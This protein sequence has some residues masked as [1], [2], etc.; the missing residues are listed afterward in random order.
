MPDDNPNVI[1]HVSLGTNR[2]DEAKS[3]YVS[4]LATLGG[5]I[6]MEHPGAVA[7]GKTYPE[8]WLQVPY[9]GKP[10][11]IGNGWHVGFVAASKAEVDAFH[12]AALAAGA[13]PDGDPGHRHEYG[14]PYYGC[15]LRDLDGN[16]I[17]ATFWDFDLARK[18]GM[19]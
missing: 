7:F 18:L 11:S 9:D 8:F 12:A 17:E 14:E 19:A 10:A 5:K 3:F 4:V 2:Y 6:V 15:F 13:T 16:K 1:S